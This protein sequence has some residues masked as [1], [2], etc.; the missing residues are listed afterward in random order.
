[1]FSA[2]WCN[3]NLGMITIYRQAWSK[4]I[5]LHL[6]FSIAHSSLFIASKFVSPQ[7][8]K[9]ISNTTFLSQNTVHFFF[10]GGGWNC[11]TWTSLSWVI[12]YTTI[13]WIVLILAQYEPPMFHCLWQFDFKK[14]HHQNHYIAQ[15]RFNALAKH[16]VL[17][18]LV[19][20]FSTQCEHNL[21]II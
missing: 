11:F 18:T 4:A 12:L 3:E 14:N 6:L 2:K 5:L 16:L 8:K 1:M 15:W 7:G 21:T 13:P 17:C 19:N 9:S 10:G 20:I